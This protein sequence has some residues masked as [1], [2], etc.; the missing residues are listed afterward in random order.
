M[1]ENY[2]IKVID[3]ILAFC[4]RHRLQDSYLNFKFNKRGHYNHKWKCKVP[5]SLQV[6]I[7]DAKFASFNELDLQLGNEYI[8][9]KF[10]SSIYY[11][12]R[13][14]ELPNG[15]CLKPIKKLQHLGRINTCIIC[16]LKLRHRD[17][18]R[19]NQIEKQVKKNKPTFS[20]DMDKFL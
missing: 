8:E 17:A 16:K 11:G 12:L 6:F 14:R 5:S 3:I 1:D 19:N 18:I 2:S 20:T 4:K 9:R 15:H 7:M 13:L 10:L